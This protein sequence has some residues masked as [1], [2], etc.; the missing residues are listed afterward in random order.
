MPKKVDMDERYE[1]LKEKYEKFLLIVKT[2]NGLD[3]PTYYLVSKKTGIAYSSV[4]YDLNDYE[5]YKVVYG[6][7]AKKV[8][9]YIQ[10]KIK[11]MKEQQSINKIMKQDE[12]NKKNNQ[13]IEEAKYYLSSNYS[14]PELAEKLKIDR[15]TLN[16]HFHKLEKIDPKLYELVCQKQKDMLLDNSNYNKQIIEEAKYYL[17][18]NYKMSDLAKKLKI[19]KSTL[20]K[21]FYKLEKIDPKLH[22]MV[23]QKQEDMLLDDSEFNKQII[24]E[25]KYFLLNNY[26]VPE[27]AKILNVNKTTLYRHFYKLEEIDPELYKLVCQKQELI[28]IG[29][30]E[31]LDITKE[32]VRKK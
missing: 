28:R 8:Y 27:L 6:L 24:E 15:S 17:D 22:D 26:T 11:V 23:R 12:E 16:R 30:S 10:G 14:I 20:H 13:I 18:N 9:D 29:T 19:S 31:E 21:H 2:F 32:T 5:K 25:A 4:A 7:K 1:R 3:N